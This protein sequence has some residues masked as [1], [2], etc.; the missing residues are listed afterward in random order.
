[1][2]SYNSNYELRINVIFQILIMSWL[3]INPFLYTFSMTLPVFISISKFSVLGNPYG[4]DRNASLSGLIPNPVDI[5][6]NPSSLGLGEDECIS[7][8]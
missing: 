2:I 6:I 1:M 8:Y 5:K 4:S 3:I 7:G